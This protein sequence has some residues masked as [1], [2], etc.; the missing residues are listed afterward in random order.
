MPRLKL[1]GKHRCACGAAMTYGPSPDGEIVIIGCT[2]VNCPRC[3]IAVQDEHLA[4][5]WQKRT[6]EEQS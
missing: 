2:N 5:E 1:A 6:G 4:G 3:F